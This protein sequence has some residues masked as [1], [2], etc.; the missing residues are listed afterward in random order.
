MAISDAGLSLRLPSTPPASER[1]NA[2]AEK[3]R[4][5]FV[6]DIPP[7]TLCLMRR[8]SANGGVSLFQAKIQRKKCHWNC[9]E[10]N[11]VDV[12]KYETTKA[13]SIVQQV[14]GH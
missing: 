4:S 10:F 11:S 7:L 8:W 6:A 9:G 13:S 1:A 12:S 5:V 3:R 2:Y 14:V